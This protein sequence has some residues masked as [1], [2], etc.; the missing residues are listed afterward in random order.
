MPGTM[1]NT[2]HAFNLH[3]T[4]IINGSHFSDENMEATQLS[5]MH[6]VIL[7]FSL[8]SEVKTFGNLIYFSTYI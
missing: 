1:L 6:K 5:N 8:S 2:L 7:L 4:G 3:K